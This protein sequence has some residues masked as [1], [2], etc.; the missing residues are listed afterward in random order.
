MSF[1]SL[2]GVDDVAALPVEWFIDTIELKENCEELTRAAREA[3][4][5]RKVHKCGKSGGDG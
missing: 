2:N 4:C 5:Y 3:S 1:A